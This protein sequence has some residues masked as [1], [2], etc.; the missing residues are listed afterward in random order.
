M[1]NTGRGRYVISQPLY[2][3]PLNS[4]VTTPFTGPRSV[5]SLRDLVLFNSSIVNEG[6]HG[7]NSIRLSVCVHLYGMYSVLGSGIT[8]NVPNCELFVDHM[9]NSKVKFAN[10]L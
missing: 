2:V 4:L 1:H 3:L 5:V 6:P 8:G 9:F 7:C 10:A